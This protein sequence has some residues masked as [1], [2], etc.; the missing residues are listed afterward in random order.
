MATVAGASRG[1]TFSGRINVAYICVKSYF[2]QEQLF[3][4]PP[5]FSILN[6]GKPVSPFET[7]PITMRVAVASLLIYY[8]AHD[9]KLKLSAAHFQPVYA[10]L[11][12]GVMVMFGSLSF[13]SVVAGLFPARVEPGL[14]VLYA[15]F[16]ASQLVPGK[17]Q[18]LWNWV[19]R[20]VMG[21]RRRE[22]A[23]PEWRLMSSIGRGRQVMAPATVNRG[24]L[25]PL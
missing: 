14:W 17:I 19:H 21:S 8:F 11:A 1:W 2:F 16:V 4:N 10:R 22:M 5:P 23:L 7:R 6:Q 25:L 15:L 3:P 9:A 20:K 13:V 18:Q 24:G 12:N